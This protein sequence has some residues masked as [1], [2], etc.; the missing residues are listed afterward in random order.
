ME[1]PRVVPRFRSVEDV[2]NKLDSHGPRFVVDTSVLIPGA[3]AVYSEGFN[4]VNLPDELLPEHAEFIDY[5]LS[6]YDSFF[7]PSQRKEIFPQKKRQPS[8]RKVK[9][10]HNPKL[11]SYKRISKSAFNRCKVKISHQGSLAEEDTIALDGLG[12]T[13]ALNALSYVGGLRG[14][15]E[16]LSALTLYYN[17]V[18]EQPTYLLSFNVNLCR[19]TNDAWTYLLK[20]KQAT[21]LGKKI[22]RRPAPNLFR[23]VHEL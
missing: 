1:I 12:Y 21:S 19:T 9:P 5:L 15:K 16:D 10:F 18:Q 7:V 2:V 4:K 3:F 14:V 22:R 23:C 8:Y 13:R 11:S 17:L 20:H 6:S